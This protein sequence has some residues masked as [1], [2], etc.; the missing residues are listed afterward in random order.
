MNN[1]IEILRPKRLVSGGIS[2]VNDTNQRCGL[3]NNQP[4]YGYVFVQESFTGQL[5]DCVLAAIVRGWKFW[6][7][8]YAT[9]VCVLADYDPQTWIQVLPTGSPI[10]LKSGIASKDLLAAWDTVKGSPFMG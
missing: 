10:V 9:N 1:K 5:F 3:K 4:L 2:Y 8:S 7:Y 6:T